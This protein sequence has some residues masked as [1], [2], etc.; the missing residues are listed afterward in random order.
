MHDD[1]RDQAAAQRRIAR[2]AFGGMALVAML[3]GL[4]IWQFADALGRPPHRDLLLGPAVHPP[5]LT[6][7]YANGGLVSN[8][9]ELHDAISTVR[10]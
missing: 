5:E 6:A 4:A 9:D 2:L 10:V 7:T 8:R 1:S 3:A